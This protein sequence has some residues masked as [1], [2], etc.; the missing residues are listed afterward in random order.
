MLKEPKEANGR[1]KEEGKGARGAREVGNPSRWTINKNLI[2]QHARTYTHTH[3]QNACAPV[4][5]TCG[6]WRSNNETMRWN[7]TCDRHTS[8]V[9]VCGNT[10][11]NYDTRR[12]DDVS[13]DVGSDKSICKLIPR[14]SIVEVSKGMRRERL[15]SVRSRKINKRQRQRKKEDREKGSIGI[16][17]KIQS[18]QK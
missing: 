8:S 9:S 16:W 15:F 13:R 3:T 11:A 6:M 17:I 4:Y 1:R 14:R 7:H 18:T 12:S 2:K 5:L 10:H